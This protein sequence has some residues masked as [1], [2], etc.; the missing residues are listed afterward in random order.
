MHFQ[1]TILGGVNSWC[2]YEICVKLEPGLLGRGKQVKQV[3]PLA[4]SFLVKLGDYKVIS[5]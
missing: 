2:V 1:P 5:G 4:S 3:V